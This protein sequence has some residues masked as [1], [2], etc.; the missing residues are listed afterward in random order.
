LW[1]WS[2]YLYRKKSLCLDS[3]FFYHLFT[4]YMM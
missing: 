4:W 3:T 2:D 1:S